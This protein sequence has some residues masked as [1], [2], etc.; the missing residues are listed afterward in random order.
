MPL[1]HSLCQGTGDASTGGA[2]TVPIDPIAGICST[3]N[4]G[5]QGTGPPTTG[6]DH[7]TETGCLAAMNQ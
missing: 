3:T 7:P 1:C 4:G 2:A 5:A 6:P